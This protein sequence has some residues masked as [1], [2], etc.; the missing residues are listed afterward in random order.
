MNS[1]TEAMEGEPVTI[2]FLDP[3]LHEFV[4]TEEEDIKKLAEAKARQLQ[5]SK[6]SLILCMSLTRCWDTEDAVWQLP[7]RRLPRCRPQR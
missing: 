2:R 7:I 3:P 1:C 4:P 5:I 6:Q